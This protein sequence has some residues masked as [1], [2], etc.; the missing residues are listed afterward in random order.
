MN[1]VISEMIENHESCRI[2]TDN[3]DETTVMLRP[4]I[5]R[6]SLKGKISDQDIDTGMDI[7]DKSIDLASVMNN[8]YRQCICTNCPEK[9]NYSLRSIPNGNINA[10][11]MFINSKPTIYEVGRMFSHCD[12]DS[13][14]LSMVLSKAGI[15]RDDLY[16]TDIVKCIPLDSSYDFPKICVSNYLIKE[17]SHISP[18]AIVCNGIDTLRTLAGI[19][20]IQGLPE[21]VSYGT[22]YP[23]VI[24]DVQVLITAI[25]DINTMLSKEGEEYEKCKVGLWGQLLQIFKKIGGTNNG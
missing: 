13:V 11:V 21:T 5:I 8:L 17:I 4:N 2:I 18:K 16:F 15:R 19:G 22:I 20:F 14:C 24:N 25:Y 10:K 23:V 3:Q 7:I 9:V 12:K 6:E 1:T